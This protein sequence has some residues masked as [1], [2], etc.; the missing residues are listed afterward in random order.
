MC[1]HNVCGSLDLIYIAFLQIISLSNW[2][3]FLKNITLCRQDKKHHTYVNN[4]KHNNDKHDDTHGSAV[5]GRPSHWW[6]WLCERH[7]SWGQHHQNAKSW[8]KSES[9]A[10]LIIVD[11]GS[12]VPKPPSSPPL[13]KTWCWSSSEEVLWSHMR[14]QLADLLVCAFGAF[15]SFLQLLA[16]G[17]WC[18]AEVD[19]LTN[20]TVWLSPNLSNG[21]LSRGEAG[22]RWPTHGGNPLKI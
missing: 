4:K 15:Y 5:R 10:K 13:L 14:R 3:F 21:N 7:W 6:E 12:D 19:D 22:P 16:E 20:P 9:P 1:T 2:D 18:Y 17:K 8:S 11:L